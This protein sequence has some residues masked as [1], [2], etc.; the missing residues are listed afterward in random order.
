MLRSIFILCY[1]N[2]DCFLIFDGRTGIFHENIHQFCDQLKTT[3]CLLMV[4][5][6]TGR[7][8]SI[9]HWFYEDECMVTW[10]K[11]NDNTTQQTV[12]QR[13]RKQL[14]LFRLWNKTLGFLKKSLAETDYRREA[15]YWS[16][17]VAQLQT[18][19]HTLVIVL[20]VAY[21]RL[22]V[23]HRILKSLTKIHDRRGLKRSF[24]SAQI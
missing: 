8:A 2:W 3:N 7:T 22:G 4:A 20:A 24:F 1:Q 12:G 23:G 9:N 18:F 17:T 19:V 14:S 5:L 11:N 13:K 6:K 21:R 16:F 15:K 10:G